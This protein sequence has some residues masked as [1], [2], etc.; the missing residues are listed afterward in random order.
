MH[1]TADDLTAAASSAYRELKGGHAWVGII[2]LSM[3]G[4][5]A[6][7]LAAN[8]PDLP[9]LGLVA[10]YLAMPRSIELAARLSW[11]WGWFIPA[12]RSGDSVSILDPAE[13]KRSLAYGVF[14]A[15]ALRALRSTMHRAAIALPGVAAPTLVIQS[16]QDNRI[17]VDAATRAFARLGAREKR[18]DWVTGAAHIV[19]VDY[20]WE[21]VNAALMAWLQE[22]G[23]RSA[24]NR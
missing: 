21:M 11:L 13:Q 9:A 20:G 22:H 23:A 14:S 12:L 7:Q 2:G 3:G 15:A 16:R 17:S 5:L 24:V 6:V 4:A 1:V 8:D 19:T 18:L 10:P